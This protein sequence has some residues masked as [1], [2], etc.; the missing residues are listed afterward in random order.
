VKKPRPAWLD[1]SVNRFKLLPPSQ[2][3]I[4]LAR[5]AGVDTRSRP[6]IEH[7]RRTGEVNNT[8]EV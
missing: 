8:G 1:R 5:A 3:I 4:A 6:A 7:W 2:R